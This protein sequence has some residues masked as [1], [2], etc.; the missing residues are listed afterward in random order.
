MNQ[1]KRKL[2]TIHKA[3]NPKDGIDRLYLSRREGEKDLASIEDSV[4]ALI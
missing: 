2:M 4:D 1:R 3:L